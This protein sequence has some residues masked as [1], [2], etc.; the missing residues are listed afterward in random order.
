MIQLFTFLNVKKDELSKVTDGLLRDLKY[1]ATASSQGLRR[2][3]SVALL[4]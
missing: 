2:V 1:Y 4:S 3:D